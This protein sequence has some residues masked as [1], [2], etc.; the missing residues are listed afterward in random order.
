MLVNTYIAPTFNIV[1]QSLDMQTALCLNLGVNAQ[2]KARK[3]N[4]LYANRPAAGEVCHVAE[5]TSQYA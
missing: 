2:W 3:H 1:I 5:I 4:I